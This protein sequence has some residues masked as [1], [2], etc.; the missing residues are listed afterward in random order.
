[1]RSLLFHGPKRLLG[2]PQE[3]VLFREGT[4]DRDRDASRPDRPGSG[5]S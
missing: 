4:S 5:S 2:I 3:T 1:V